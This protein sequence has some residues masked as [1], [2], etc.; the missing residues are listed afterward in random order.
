MK[1]PWRRKAGGV[2][3]RISS[4]NFLL[5]GVEPTTHSGETVW[6][7]TY[8]ARAGSH[9][10]DRRHRD[11]RKRRL[12]VKVR[13]GIDIAGRA[14]HQA[15]ATDET[16]EFLWSGW[17]SRTTPADLGALWAK[18]PE[19][20]EVTVIMEPTR[21]A[22]VPLAAWLKARDATVV[23]V[24]PE[25]SADLRD[26]YAKHTKTDRLDS[27]MLARL[28]LLHPEGLE[29]LHGLGPAGTFKRTVRR[30]WS[31]VERRHA[32]C[33][34]LD[35]LVEM[36]GPSY[37]EVLGATSYTDTAFAVLERYSGPRALR[38]LGRQRLT[39]LVRRVSRGHFAEAKA[40]E[41]LAAAD[42]ALS[43][44]AGG[45]LDFAELAADIASEIR[46]VR[47][48]GDEISRL[49]A[50]IEGLY[51]QIDPEGI[52]LSAPGLGVTLAAG[53]LGRFGDLD[54]FATSL[55]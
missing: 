28:P 19:G 31:L 50:R 51:H 49:D 10:W 18:L 30:R 8:E 9:H 14:H 35:A 13:L 26:Y 47:A 52:V 20:A 5:P 40:D 33:Q 23:L 17:R 2:A 34:R 7:S 11:Y 44:W 53:I 46:V 42:E 12:S 48:L 55:V 36:L 24:A 37:A 1:T 22:W 38:R 6:N 41:L 45:G 32:C 16:G 3:A 25:R 54:R 39:D 15:S 29:P 4:S 21:N 27:P 43:L